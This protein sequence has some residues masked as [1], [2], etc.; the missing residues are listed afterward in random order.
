MRVAADLDE[1]KKSLIDFNRSLVVTLGQLEDALRHADDSDFANG[2]DWCD[3][4]A[5]D[6]DLCFQAMDKA[7]NPARSKDETFKAAT[8]AADVLESLCDRIGRKI[9]DEVKSHI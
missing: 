6:R 1:L 7:I 8:E 9:E 5:V 4:F 3:E 2:C